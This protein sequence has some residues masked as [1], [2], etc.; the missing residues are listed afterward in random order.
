ME[1]NEIQEILNKLRDGELEE[2]CVS[3]DDFMAFR[4]VLVNREDFKHFQGIA[5]HGGN[6]IYRYHKVPRS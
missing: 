1:E 6:I 4:Q 2:Y 5:Q 3:K